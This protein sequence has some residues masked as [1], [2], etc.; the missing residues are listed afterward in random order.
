M[1]FRGELLCTNST[2]VRYLTCLLI[3]DL[4]PLEDLLVVLERSLFG[5]D[6]LSHFIDHSLVLLHFILELLGAIE[7]LVVL[8]LNL[9]SYAVGVVLVIEE[10][11]GCELPEFEEFNHVLVPHQLQVLLLE[12]R[13][14]QVRE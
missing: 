8:A 12:L 2:F 3:D 5:L 7:L 4:R 10:V 11:L 14:G 6:L 1:V 9:P 13:H